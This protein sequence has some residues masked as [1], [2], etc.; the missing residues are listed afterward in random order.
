MQASKDEWY[1]YL[2]QADRAIEKLKEG[3][4]E[5]KQDPDDV[6]IEMDNGLHFNINNEEVVIDNEEIYNDDNVPTEAF[7]DYASEVSILG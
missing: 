1:L 6:Y 3:V 7:D 4:V 2:L 5:I